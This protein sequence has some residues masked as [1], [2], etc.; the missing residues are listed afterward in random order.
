MIPV[1][2]RSA[3]A[4]ALAI[5]VGGAAHAPALAQDERPDLQIEI[6][7]LDPND[8]TRVRVRVTNVGKWWADHTTATVETTAPTRGNKVEEDVLDLDP[9]QQPQGPTD[10]KY[11]FTYR[12]A[13]ACR[14]GVKV[15]DN[16]STAVT[17]NGNTEANGDRFSSGAHQPWQPSWG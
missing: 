4:L 1:L 17:F 3:G 13:A 11:E 14:P 7:G 5:L 16:L 12:L 6:V 2:R 10:Y 15:K 8:P 9:K